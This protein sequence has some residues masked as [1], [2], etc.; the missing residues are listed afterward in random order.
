MP[1][2]IT[3]NLSLDEVAEKIE[4][5]WKEY[6]FVVWLKLKKPSFEAVH[7]TLHFY[8]HDRRHWDPDNY[9]VT[10]S[11]LVGDALKGC[12]IQDDNPNHLT[13]PP[14]RYKLHFE[15]KILV[16]CSRNHRFII[17]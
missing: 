3:S 8:F 10:G 7:I 1:M 14:W 6:V 13:G 16:Y 4:K 5:T 15:V 12:L 17:K 2:V 11:K 9:I